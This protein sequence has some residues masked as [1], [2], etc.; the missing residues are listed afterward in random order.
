MAILKGLN[1]LS[2]TV[3]AGPKSRAFVDI[4]NAEVALSM[5]QMGLRNAIIVD[6]T[7][8]DSIEVVEQP[9]VGRA[10]PKSNGKEITVDLR[11]Y[12][13]ETAT[14]V[15]VVYNR[16]KNGAT[17][18]VRAT[19]TVEPAPWKLG[20]GVGDFYN[21]ESDRV[22][23][24]TIVEPSSRDITRKIH[25]APVG[26]G[27]SAQD[28]ANLEPGVADNEP[29][30]IN[31][32]WIWDNLANGSSYHYG[33]TEALAIDEVL[34]R[35]AWNGVS[36]NNF[37]I[38]PNNN[39]NSPW[40]LFKRGGT[41]DERFFLKATRGYSALH[42]VLIS[43]WG[44]GDAPVFTVDDAVWAIANEGVR[45]VVLQ[46][47][48]K[49]HVYND[50]SNSNTIV[51]GFR[52]DGKSHAWEVAGNGRKFR[53]TLRRA[54]IKNAHY[55]IPQQG[56]EQW[57]NFVGDRAGNTYVGGSNKALIEYCFFDH[58]GYEDGYRA[59]CTYDDGEGNF[60][61]QPPTQG[62]H[63]GYYQYDN[64]EMT[65]SNV[66]TSFAAFQGIQARSGG[67][68]QKVV[69]LA[70]NSHFL[71]GDSI[72]LHGASFA[73]G[74]AVNNTF[75]DQVICLSGGF[76]GIWNTNNNAPSVAEHQ[77]VGFVTNDPYAY[78]S[79]CVLGDVDP[80]RSD[81]VT[82]TGPDTLGPCGVYDG[83]NASTHMSVQV[84]FS[85]IDP[86]LPAGAEP[87]PDPDWRPIQIFNWANPSSPNYLVDGIDQSVLNVTTAGAYNDYKM[88]T[89][90][91]EVS[92]LVDRFHT[93]DT[94][95]E[96][97]P[98]MI[99]WVRSRLGNSD[100]TIRSVAQTVTFSPL[101][102][103]KSPGNKAYI[104]ADWDTSDWPGTV[105][106]DSVNLDGHSIAWD[107]TPDNSI[108]DFTFGAGAEIYV[109]AGILE[110]T[111]DFIVDDDGNRVRIGN[112]AKMYIN[113]VSGTGSFPA[114]V[115]DGRWMNKTTITG[116]I[117]LNAR[118]RSEVVLAWNSGSFTL[119]DGETLTVYGGS[120][121]GFDGT[122]GG[123]TS[124]VLHSGSTLAFKPTYKMF[125]ESIIGYNIPKEGYE[126]TGDTSGA[127]GICREYQY[128][129]GYDW[130][131]F[132][133][134]LEGVF[135][136]SETISG[137][138]TRGPDPFRGVTSA[139]GSVRVAPFHTYGSITEFETGINGYSGDDLVATDVDSVVNLGGA[140]LHL[141]VTG[142]G[143]N[144]YTLI[145]VDTV[146]G[147]FGAVTAAGN[148]AKDLTV[149]IT[150]STVTVLVED[151]TGT[152]TGGTS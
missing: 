4:G 61:P 81:F 148:S 17:S 97:I 98:E 30:R 120:K 121:V 86:E 71:I 87:A 89:T 60:Y 50:D 132:L 45:N 77:A 111:G 54:I 63:N 140:T 13:P 12:D 138:T 127:T 9:A 128:R 10:I 49:V 114:D 11:E 64:Q 95:W 83:V 47:I 44:T 142:L 118:Y 82:L 79:R 8:P 147:V 150:G 53:H 68:V 108:D 94:P 113:G 109:C 46:D 65:I 14:D 27:L 42:P 20:W 5:T 130:A 36:G 112:G 135:Q 28:I 85:W 55:D 76:R 106:G 48:E 3:S 107:I 67:E 72:Q 92:D 23:K 116:G 131:A 35:D 119:G 59:D 103:G 40:L 52:H 126:I 25:I 24:K 37:S 78:F 101:S 124:L 26:V 146:S 117:S 22:T 133:D 141:D 96:E 57:D 66:I 33:E 41:Y 104:Y 84:N 19:I 6:P 73:K 91:S 136:Q 99:N 149:S 152:V 144:T 62:S 151:G 18:R 93:M 123:T 80:I 32:D 88:S 38:K 29:W 100:T 115:Q 125:G 43:T 145:D 15:E 137:E 56:R 105:D 69:S 129:V 31:G 74:N 90:G 1:G 139:Y 2:G 58:A 110:P 122:G 39:E 134:D 21:L 16:V 102:N 143:N 75:V 34:A 51:D 7:E 70:N